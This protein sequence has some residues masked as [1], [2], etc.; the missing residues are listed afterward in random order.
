[1]TIGQLLYDNANYQMIVREAWIQRRKKRY[2]LPAVAVNFAQVED[3]GA[4]VLT[5]EVDGCS[6]HNVPIDGGS[7]VNLILEDTHYDLGYTTLETT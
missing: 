2:K 1:M 6:I 5:V 7:G 4:P 3:F